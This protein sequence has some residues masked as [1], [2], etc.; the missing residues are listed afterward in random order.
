MACPS[1][2][3]N[4]MGSVE[5]AVSFGLSLREPHVNGISAG[6]HPLDLAG[7]LQMPITASKKAIPIRQN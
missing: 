7:C 4:G 3:G 2:R 1:G 5:M 6:S